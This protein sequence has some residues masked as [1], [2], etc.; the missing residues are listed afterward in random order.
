MPYRT[1]PARLVHDSHITT[2]VSAKAAWMYG[3]LE[4]SGVA[5]GAELVVPSAKQDSTAP[6]NAGTIR[7]NL[8]NNRQCIG[9]LSTKRK[10]IHSIPHKFSCALARV[11]IS[12]ANELS[13][14]I[15]DSKV[16]CGS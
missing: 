5:A 8:K 3:P 2:N 9:I 11:R 15:I 10:V 13:G 12:I 7:T 14:A 16:I 4:M 1:V 6:K